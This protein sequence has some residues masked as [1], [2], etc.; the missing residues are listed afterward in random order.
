MFIRIF[1]V[2]S[3]LA[4]QMKTNPLEFEPKRGIVLGGSI[5]FGDGNG[6]HDKDSEE[7]ELQHGVRL[8]RV[9]RFRT[10]AN[11]EAD[12]AKNKT[13]WRPERAA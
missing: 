3:G 1:P 12:T 7:E 5:G 13:D 10:H 6:S 11:I 4:L 9:S 2:E 8:I